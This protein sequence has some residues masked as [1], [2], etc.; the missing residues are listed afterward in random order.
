LDEPDE[1]KE[2]TAAYRAGQD[3]LADFLADI[4]DTGPTFQE[5]TAELYRTYCWWCKQSKEFA[6]T[7]RKFGNLLEERGYV[8]A[9]TSFARMWRG[10]AIRAGQAAPSDFKV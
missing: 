1:V 7:K 9:R 10:L 8:Q 5:S 6:V 3:V 4:C 2:A